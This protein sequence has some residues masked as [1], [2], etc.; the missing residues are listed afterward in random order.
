MEDHVSSFPA[1]VTGSRDGRHS[2]EEV[3]T[4]ALPPVR[5][6]GTGRRGTVDAGYAVE[7]SGGTTLAGKVVWLYPAPGGTFT[8]ASPG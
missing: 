2:W 7:V 1:E 5:G 3:V 6:N 4:D 8:F